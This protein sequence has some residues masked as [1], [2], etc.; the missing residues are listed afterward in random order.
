MAKEM[1][2]MHLLTP[3]MSES[4]SGEY[5]FCLLSS[6]F[7]ILDPGWKGKMV[8]ITTERAAD[9]VVGNEGLCV[10]LNVRLA[11][12]FFGICAK[13]T[14]CF[15]YPTSKFLEEAHPHMSGYPRICLLHVSLAAYTQLNHA[16]LKFE[17][18]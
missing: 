9:M 2:K 7:D 17:L 6:V 5:I 1:E 11:M 14:R 16:E 18:R 3:P 8:G 12:D 10:K 4:H 15:S 13:L